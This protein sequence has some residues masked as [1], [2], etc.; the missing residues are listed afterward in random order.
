MLF[1]KATPL[2]AFH[3]GQFGCVVCEVLAVYISQSLPRSCVLVVWDATP[4]PN[5]SPMSTFAYD[6]VRGD[7]GM[8][9]SAGNSATSVLVY[10]EH[11]SD[12]LSLKV[13]QLKF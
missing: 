5:S 6:C 3:P 4:R 7:E 12:G 13:C 8:V 2:T 1:T 11:V 9:S 10:G